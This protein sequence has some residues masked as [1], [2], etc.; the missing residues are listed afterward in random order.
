V[1]R[2][3]VL[4]SCL[5][6]AATAGAETFDLRERGRLEIFAAGD[7]KITGEDLGDRLE[8][9]L[10]PTRGANA[11][12]R[13]V[14]NLTEKDEHNTKALLR[15]RV[16]VLCQPIAE[17]HGVRKPTAEPFYSRQGFG[18]HCSFTDP[19]LVGKPPEKGN[20][21]HV[22][23]GVVRLAPRV[24]VAVTILADDFAGPDYQALLGAVEG[25]ELHP[26]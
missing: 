15:A 20:Y 10:T 1:R 25:M 14:V 24:Y 3:S 4:L 13:L 22:T 17:E 5:L 21:K 2:G 16:L 12:A 23:Y 11:G 7:W 9:I 6:L 19:E 18:Y 8:I 26:R